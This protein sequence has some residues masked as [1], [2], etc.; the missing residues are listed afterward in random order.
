MA[1][2]LV[3]PDWVN[4]SASKMQRKGVPR[5]RQARGDLNEYREASGLGCKPGSIRRPLDKIT[6]NPRATL[7]PLSPEASLQGYMRQSVDPTKLALGADYR[8]D[9]ELISGVGTSRYLATLDKK[10]PSS[11]SRTRSS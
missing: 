8:C 9:I 3:L 7:Y 1:S 10:I 4:G 5:A 6:S 2:L 11:V